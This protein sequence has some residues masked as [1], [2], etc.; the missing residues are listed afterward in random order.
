MNGRFP[1]ARAALAV[2]PMALAAVSCGSGNGS[3][4]GSAP[5]VQAID[6]ASTAPV[7]YDV[8]VN[9][10]SVVTD[11]VYGQ[12]TALDPIATGTTTL[13]FEASGTTTVD[14]TATFPADDGYDYSVFV[15]QGSSA[16]TTLTVG[17]SNAAAAVDRAILG[18][19]N[20]APVAGTLDIYLTAP[21]ATLPASP[22]LSAL[23]YAGD[24]S[25]VL[26][27][28]LP[29]ISSGDYQIRAVATG[30]SARTVVYDSGPV[31]IASGANLLYAMV[32]VTGSAASFALLTPS[33]S[34]GISELLDQRVQIRAAN[35]SPNVGGVDAY[36][37]PQGTAIGTLSPLQTDLVFG[38]GPTP[39]QTVYPGTYPVFTLTGAVTE[40]AG[41]TLPLVAS[42]ARSLFLVGIDG[43][44]SPHQLQ[45]L[46]AS[47][48]LSAPPTGMAKLRV[49]QLAPDISNAGVGGVTT[50][51]VDVVR[52]SNDGSTTTVSGPL[53]PNL[54]YLGAS[55]YVVLAPG[56][57]NLALVPTGVQSPILPAGTAGTSV[58]LAAGAIQ[59]V[60]IYGCQSPG[61]GICAGSS[62]PLTLGVY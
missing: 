42:S 5:S 4:S 36:L 34:G 52:V 62:A 22:S 57:Y 53:V 2:L 18:F 35:F 58:S 45:V 41:S 19:A 11:L 25:S 50:Q 12:A 20:A 8:L 9:G 1:G 26:S 55:S 33:A 24:A 6:E 13:K 51:N 23:A 37:D 28:L 54:A 14:L 40:L 43:A 46:L 60:I 49:I 21:G 31:G 29:T 7:G 38:T 59:T 27:T 39:Y 61:G 47:D 16:V 15:I 10:T 32:P 56:T 44:P 17:Q 3:G 30:D 48:D